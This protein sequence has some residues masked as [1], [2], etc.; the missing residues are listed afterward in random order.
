MQK[1]TLQNDSVRLE[2]TAGSLE[3]G[4]VIVT[5]PTSV[6]AAGAITFD[7]PLPPAYHRRI[8][9]TAPRH[10]EQGVLQPAAGRD[11]LRG[12]HA[13]DRQRHFR[14]HGELHA[15]SR[16]ARPLISAFFGGDL[17]REL[18]A[19]HQLAEF[20]REELRQMLGSAVTDRITAAFETDWEGDPF[21]RGSY[22]AARPGHAD[23]RAVIAQHVD[24][25]L[26]FAGESWSREYYGTLHGAWLS[27][28]EAA[29]HLLRNPTAN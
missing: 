7:P 4:A 15:A 26:L 21:A 23:A 10:R 2:T 11:S 12:N 13:D 18:G 14:A 27:G 5:V 28:R 17:S 24:R 9:G 29:D 8:R 16:Q 1:I 19:K 3:A 6:L 20:A 25:R 22:S